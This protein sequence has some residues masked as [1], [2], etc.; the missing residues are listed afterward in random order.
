MSK[1]M[2]AIGGETKLIIKENVNNVDEFNN[3]YDAVGWE[4]YDKEI[5]EIALKNTMYSVSVYDNDKNIG[6]GRLIGDEICFIYVQDIMVLPEY[7]GKKIGT[8]I[9]N[10]LLAKIE[11]IKKRNPDLMVYCGASKNKEDYY[12]KF[13]FITRE[14][15]GVGSGMILKDD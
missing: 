1:E 10:R 13:G 11:E 6:F 9:M 5:S 8:M 12:R 4:H 7:Q 14:E 2:I 15:F 3:L